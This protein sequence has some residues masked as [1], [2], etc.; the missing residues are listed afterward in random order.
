MTR[1]IVNALARFISPGRMGCVYIVIY[2]PG[3]VNS[4]NDSEFYSFFV[5]GKATDESFVVF[6]TPVPFQG[7]SYIVVES[8][9]TRKLGMFLFTARCSSGSG[10]R[11]AA[12]PSP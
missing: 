2:N 1:N 6:V 3:V 10:L 7:I 5:E 8:S 4:G 12:H 11:S 9:Y